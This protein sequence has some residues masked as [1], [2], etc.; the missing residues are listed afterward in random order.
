MCTHM[1]HGSWQNG[2]IMIQCATKISY[3]NISCTHLY[4]NIYKK[5]VPNLCLYFVVDIQHIR[6]DKQNIIND[7]WFEWDKDHSLNFVIKKQQFH[8][9][10]HNHPCTCSGIGL[11][12]GLFAMFIIFTSCPEHT[13]NALFAVLIRK[14]ISSS[15]WVIETRLFNLY[16][17]F[18]VHFHRQAL[19]HNLFNNYL[20]ISSFTYLCSK[21][22]VV[23][24]S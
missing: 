12:D 6:W 5:F 7:E 17:T 14:T 3:A 10:T 2:N 11:F 20:R 23:N 4:C 15:F 18:F 22:L 1:F 19:L 13:T 9:F 21:I 16:F 24:F 8:N